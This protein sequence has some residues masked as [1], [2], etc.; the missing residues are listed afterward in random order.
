MLCTGAAAEARRP[1]HYLVRG[2]PDEALLRKVSQPS[3]LNQ[4]V[5]CC[6]ECYVLGVTRFSSIYDLYTLDACF[7]LGVFFFFLA[8]L[9]DLSSQTRDR[10]YGLGSGG[11]EF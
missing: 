8:A 1:A 11:V 2:I 9:H 7:L 10:I 4:T 3:H 5:L 6:E